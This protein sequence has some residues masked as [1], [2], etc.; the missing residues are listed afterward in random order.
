MFDFLLNYLTWGG[1]I[2][3]SI[4]LTILILGLIITII[5]SI[6]EMF[7]TIKESKIDKERN[8]E[9]QRLINKALEDLS[10]EVK[11]NKQTSDFNNGAC[12]C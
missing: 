8:E 12:K 5:F 4:L 2:I 11:N 1:L 9:K 7:E 10:K 6:I 3:G